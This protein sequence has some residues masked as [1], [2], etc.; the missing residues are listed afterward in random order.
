MKIITEAQEGKYPSLYRFIWTAE[1]TEPPL[2]VII[3][4]LEVG[5]YVE[6]Q[7][8]LVSHSVGNDEELIETVRWQTSDER[9]LS[10]I[11][12]AAQF[13]QNFFDL[14]RPGGD[15]RDDYETR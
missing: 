8:Q 10:S 5:F 12:A 6:C 2:K 14:Y 4:K 9:K 7:R 15:L 1:E 11:Q 13:R 3:T